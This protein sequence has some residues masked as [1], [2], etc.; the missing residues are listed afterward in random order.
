MNPTITNIRQHTFAV[1][2]IGLFGILS[3]IMQGCGDTSKTTAE[4]SNK[5]TVYDIEEEIYK[6]NKE[7]KLSQMDRVLWNTV[8]KLPDDKKWKN[9]YGDKLQFEELMKDHLNRQQSQMSRPF[10]EKMILLQTTYEERGL[11]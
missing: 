10:R 2:T 1:A 9:V 8:P 3:F 4:S 11:E 6:M 5:T 7:G